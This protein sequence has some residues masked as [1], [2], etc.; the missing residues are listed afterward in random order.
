MRGWNQRFCVWARWPQR[1]GA[2]DA[3]R[4]G[5]RRSAAAS[6][7]DRLPIWNILKTHPCI[8]IFAKT[9]PFWIA[10]INRDQNIYIKTPTL[11]RRLIIAIRYFSKTTLFWIATINRDPILFAK[12]SPLTRWQTPLAR[13]PPASTPPEPRSS[14]SPISNHP[15]S[16]PNMRPP[17]I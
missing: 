5:Y 9:T 14:V 4:R 2:L 16:S 10:V 8:R 12:K 7:D 6:P 17:L 15:A 13:P 3:R 11:D 1:K